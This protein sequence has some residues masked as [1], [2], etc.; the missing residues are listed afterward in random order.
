MLPSEGYHTKLI[1]EVAG[2]GGDVFF[3]KAEVQ[4]EMFKE[5]IPQWVSWSNQT[6]NLCMF[7]KLYIISND[8]CYC[9]TKNR[10]VCLIIGIGSLFLGR[11]SKAIFSL[12][13]QR[14]LPTGWSN[15]SPRF[16]YVGGG[17]S[18]PRLQLRRRGL[19]GYGASSIPASP[20]HHWR[21]LS[22]NKDPQ[23]LNCWKPYQTV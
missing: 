20:I 13:N 4:T 10:L 22:E 6:S 19:L 18:S 12:K 16:Q 17:A 14:S 21:V 3:S 7:L 15:D 8:V 9:V 11:T 5:I 23:F 1:H 2:L